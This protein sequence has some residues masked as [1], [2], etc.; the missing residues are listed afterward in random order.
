MENN[1]DT[2]IPIGSRLAGT[3]Y[4]FTNLGGAYRL[5][6]VDAPYAEQRVGIFGTWSEMWA[7]A[8]A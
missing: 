3:D 7:F 4:F 2:R 8:N 1:T 6:R 5:Y